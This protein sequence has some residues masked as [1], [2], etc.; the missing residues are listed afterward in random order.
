MRTLK[1]AILGLLNQKSMTGY[2]L[3]QQFEGALAEFWNAK[4]SQI[5]PE[6]KRLTTEGMVTYDIKIAGTVLEKKVYTITNAGRKDFLQ[7]LSLDEPMQETAKDIFR[8]RLFFGNHLGSDR[9]MELIKSQLT[10]HQARLAQLMENQETFCGIPS[11]DTDA[12]YDYMI[13]TG[14]ILREEAYC[15]WLNVCIKM[16]G[17]EG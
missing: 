8:L 7:W 1:Y 5:Y 4:H 3:M 2:E 6:L 14:G 10:Q 12:F 16:C 11:K 15:R 17:E 13:L 9:R